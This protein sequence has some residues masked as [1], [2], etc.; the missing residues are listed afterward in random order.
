M[1][2]TAFPLP[3]LGLTAASIVICFPMVALSMVNFGL[4]SIWLNAAVAFLVLIHHIAFLA[5][6]WISRKHVSSK[7]VIIDDDESSPLSVDTDAVPP[8][9]YSLTNIACL[10]FLLI[11]NAIAFSIMVDITSRGAIKSTLPAERVGPKWNIKVQIGQT[12]VLGAEMLVLG[13]LLTI[14]AMGLKRVMD[15]K[16]NKEAELEYGLASPV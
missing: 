14:C 3:V 11:L 5:V 7:K 13:S 9:A 15:E 8:V 4:L 12:S 6:S 16:E 1:V 10:T 2:I